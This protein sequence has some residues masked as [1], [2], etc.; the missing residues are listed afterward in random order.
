MALILPLGLAV[1]GPASSAAAA[2]PAAGT[3]VPGAA[4]GD[5]EWEPQEPLAEVGTLSPRQR[6][7]AALDFPGAGA[8]APAGEFTLTAGSDLS[9]RIADLTAALPRQG[10][11]NLLAQANRT[12]GDGGACADPFGGGDPTSP[13]DPTPKP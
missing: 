8:P 7:L 11:Q 3:P 1:S 13:T 12:L 5:E 10:V 9:G 2:T 6:E 4:P